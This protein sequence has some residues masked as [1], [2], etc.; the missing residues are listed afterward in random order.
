MVSGGPDYFPRMITTAVEEEQENDEVTD[1]ETVI[2]FSKTVLAF[3]I[4]N[5]G[6]FNAHYSLSTGVSTNNFM[7][8]SG[9]GLMM[10]LPTTSIYFICA[11]GQNAF[12]YVCG[13]R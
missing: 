13:V 11:A 3:L 10:D 2:T 9:A 1:A 4:Y 7:I 12:I 8:P 6:P 5:H